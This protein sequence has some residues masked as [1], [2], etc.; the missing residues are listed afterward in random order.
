[1]LTNGM[2]FA[3]SETSLS[4]EPVASNQ[5]S[6]VTAAEMIFAEPSIELRDLCT[7]NRV[8]ICAPSSFLK[9]LKN[10]SRFAESAEE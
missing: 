9:A 4:G 8:H 5:G 10:W 7:I 3:Y 6:C 1:M 2:Y